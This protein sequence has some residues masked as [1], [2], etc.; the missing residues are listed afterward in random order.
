MSGLFECGDLVQTQFTDQAVL[1]RTE[2]SFDASFSLGGPG[3]NGT[4]VEFG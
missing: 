2:E 1:E 4:D 3:G